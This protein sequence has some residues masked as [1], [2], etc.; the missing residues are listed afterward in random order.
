MARIV[1]SLMYRI[2]DL[3]KVQR[4]AGKIY[5]ND[6]GRLLE[7][8]DIV[9]FIFRDIS[10]KFENANNTNALLFCVEKNMR[11]QKNFLT[12]F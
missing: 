5:H 10:L 1:C 3:S 9:S 4:E 2:L 11:M 7:I 8:N 6:Q 12:T